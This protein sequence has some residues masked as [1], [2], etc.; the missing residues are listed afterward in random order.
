MPDLPTRTFYAAFDA[1]SSWAAIAGERRTF[2]DRRV[3]VQH[4][5]GLLKRKHDAKDVFEGV[6]GLDKALAAAVANRLP[7]APVP[8]VVYSFRVERQAIAAARYKVK[9][10]PDLPMWALIVHRCQT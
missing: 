10:T 1:D 7:G 4:L 6:H 2:Y 8:T 9:L 5:R 3:I